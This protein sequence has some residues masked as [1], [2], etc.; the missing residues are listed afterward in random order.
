M[1]CALKGKVST[2]LKVN[3]L[4]MSWKCMVAGTYVYCSE[5]LIYTVGC[6]SRNETRW[7]RSILS[8]WMHCQPKRYSRI[9]VCVSIP[10]WGAWGR[11]SHDCILWPRL[12]ISHQTSSELFYTC[13]SEVVLEIDFADIL[14]SDEKQ[15]S[16]GS[17]PN[18]HDCVSIW[19]CQFMIVFSGTWGSWIVW[20]EKQTPCIFYVEYNIYIQGNL[21]ISRC[22]RI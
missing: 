12:V 19:R 5:Q 4:L 11:G 22:P 15:K 10:R 16:P 13:S 3:W 6:K 8:D 20:M 1:P 2:P 9:L 17:D 21:G 14:G 7:S 18:G